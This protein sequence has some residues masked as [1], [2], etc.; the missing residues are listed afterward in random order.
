MNFSI[1]ERTGP[2]KLSP[3]VNEHA[4]LPR[5]ARVTL[6]E[7]PAT[8]SCVFGER[9]PTVLMAG[10]VDTETALENSTTLLLTHG[11][12]YDTLVNQDA[13]GSRHAVRSV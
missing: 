5:E 12:A 2:H 8:I 11:V 13:A 3:T 7:I 10:E 1:R 4:T 6:V 9:W